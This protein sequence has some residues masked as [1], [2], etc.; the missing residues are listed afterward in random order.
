MFNFLK[1]HSKLPYNLK[2]NKNKMKIGLKNT[3]DKK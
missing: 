1:A 3:I 2:L